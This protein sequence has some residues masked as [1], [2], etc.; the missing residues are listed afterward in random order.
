M[1]IAFAG[2]PEV[3]LPSLRALL[4]A[5]HDIVAVITRPDAPVGRGRAMTPSP[6]AMFAQEH[7]LPLLRPARIADIAADLRALAP[8]CIPVVAYGG[9]IP[10]DLLD[11]APHG[12]IN[13]HFSLLPAWRGAAPVQRA[14]IAGDTLTGVTVFRIDAGL[15]SGPV[16]AS[17]ERAI[18]GDDTAGALLDALA[19]AGAD[20]LVETL[21]RIAGTEPTPQS[22]SG[23]TH[24]AKLSSADARIDWSQS[25]QAVDR[26]VRGCTPEPGAWTTIAGER[27]GVGPVLLRRDVQGLPPGELHFDADILVG[28]GSHAL[29]LRAVK[30]A[31]KTWMDATAWARG[32]RQQPARFD[33]D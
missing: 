10:P 25:A 5:G 22:Q 16:F 23:V 3:A 19:S 26:H 4:A 1:R 9:L 11:V 31:G 29:A 8:D 15:D 33:D 12:W 14:I 30:P 32:L 7:G 6:V 24:A 20:L 2:T 21:A 18:S 13:V 27:I 28:T 17:R